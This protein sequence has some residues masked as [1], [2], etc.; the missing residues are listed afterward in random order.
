MAKI[1]VIEDTENNRV[2][3]SRRLKSRGHVIILAEDAER[4]LC[5][6]RTDSPDLILMDVG[7]PGIDGWEATRQL[8]QDPLTRPIPV[9]ALTAHAMRQD[10]EKAAQCGCDNY[11]TKPID[12]NHLFALIDHHLVGDAIPFPP[13]APPP[14]PES[15]LPN[16]ASTEVLIDFHRLESSA[17]GN[18]D[19]LKE[20]IALYL[21]QSRELISQLTAALHGHDPEQVEH[22]AHKLKGASVACGVHALL[23][24]LNQLEDSARL[25]NLSQAGPVLDQT[26]ALLDQVNEALRSYQNRL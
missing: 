18:K 11:E 5:L 8:K 12:F 17:S 19:F 14:V 20:L 1:L 23:P 24:G 16:S 10:R 3:L 15:P 26:K 21:G 25:R 9:I 22:L 6:A 7:L 13:L 4:G 2:L